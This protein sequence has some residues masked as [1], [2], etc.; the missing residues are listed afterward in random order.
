MF[1]QTL[2]MLA[3]PTKSMDAR[4]EAIG[5][6]DSA[7]RPVRCHWEEEAHAGYCDEVLAGIETAGTAQ[8]DEPGWPS[9]FSWPTGNVRPRPTRP[10]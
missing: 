7:I 3:L 6:V 2:M 8:V 1:C 4:P 10:S 5:S 9:I